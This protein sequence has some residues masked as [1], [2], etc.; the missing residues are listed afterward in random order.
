LEGTVSDSS[1][2]FRAEAGSNKL[3]ILGLLAGKAN[4]TACNAFWLIINITP[5][6]HQKGRKKEHEK[7]FFLLTMSKMHS[8]KF[9]R[10]FHAFLPFDMEQ[11]K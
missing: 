9:N 3:I 1:F 7:P 11:D 8:F 4:I 2:R 6:D 5:S 10:L